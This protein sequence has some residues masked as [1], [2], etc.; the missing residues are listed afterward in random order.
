VQRMAG[1]RILIVKLSSLGDIF[2]ALPSVHL[3]RQGLDA[4]VDWVTQPEYVELLQCFPDVS[5]I[6]SFPRR[7]YFGKMRSFLCALRAHEYDIVVDLQG[8]M[9]SAMVAKLARARKVVGPSFYREGANLLYDEVAGPRDKD[10]HA[11]EENLDVVR[12]LGLPQIPVRF[13]VRFQ[14]MP[15]DSKGVKVALVPVSR[16]I[17]KNWPVRNFIDVASKLQKEAG[18]SIYLFGSETDVAVCEAIR[19]ALAS[20]AAGSPVVNLAGKTSLVEMGRWLAGMNLVVA[21]DSGPIH[22]AAALGVP[23]LAVFGPTDPK[24]TGPYGAIHRVVTAD[25]ACRP[26]YRKHCAQDVPECL[27]RVAPERVAQEAIDM[28]R[29]R[30]P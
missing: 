29:A 14:N 5:D 8:L 22:M 7:Q 28:L 23:V 10:R 26:C 20:D 27:A 21:N 25:I 30:S 15:I 2:H 18:A 17:H 3:L 4:E 12:H 16:G 1:K 19:S 9:K 11:V 6:I 13:P 24:R